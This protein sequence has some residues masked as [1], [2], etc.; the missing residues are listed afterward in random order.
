MKIFFRMNV[1]NVG[2]LIKATRSEF[3]IFR[4]KDYIAINK[5]PGLD[6]QAGKQ[7]GG[8]LRRLLT[9]MGLVQSDVV[10]V[11]VSNMDSGTSGVAIFSMHASAGRLARSMVKSG[12]F[13]R[14]HYWG[15]LHGRLTANDGIIS[16]PLSDGVPSADGPPSITHWRVLKVHGERARGDALSLIE[17]E[18]RTAIDNQI[19]IHCKMCLKVP[20]VDDFGLH[21]YQVNGSLPGIEQASIVAPLKGLFKGKLEELGFI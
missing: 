19:R 15:L 10:P 11:P 16:M 6:L 21:L 2:K 3:L 9:E 17:F 1:R 12:K 8:E 20:L 7:P 4:N 14:C 13:A 5:P 18:P